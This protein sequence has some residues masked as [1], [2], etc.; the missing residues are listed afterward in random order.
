VKAALFRYLQVAEQ[1]KTVYGNGNIS[2]EST[3]SLIWKKIRKWASQSGINKYGKG[4]DAWTHLASMT[5]CDLSN[6]GSV[7]AL[8][9]G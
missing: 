2:G 6:T 9:R 3:D 8:S 4:V 5:S 7:C 1:T